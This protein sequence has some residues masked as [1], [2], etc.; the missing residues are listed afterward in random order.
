MTAAEFAAIA[1]K[2]A[3]DW[4][5]IAAP[6]PKSPSRALLLRAVS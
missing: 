6:T 1:C 3:I 5:G 4:A 2:L